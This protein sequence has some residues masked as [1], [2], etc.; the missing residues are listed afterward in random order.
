MN[1]KH[2]I[3]FKITSDYN[4]IREK[5]VFKK[6]LTV[7]MAYAHKL[8][9]SK[10]LR[11]EK[12]KA[13]LAYDMAMETITKYLQE[14]KKFDPNRNPD[15][16]WYLKYNIL[17]QLIYNYKISKG[18]QNELL[19][20]P[21]DGTGS[22]VR[23]SFIQNNEIHDSLDLGIT[24]ELILKEISD[25]PILLELFELRYLK[26]FEPKEIHQELNITKGEYNNRIR[27]LDTVRKRVIKL[28]L[29][30]L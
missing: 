9:G 10:T 14:P 30:E 21:D 27:R 23:N 1:D 4:S 6:L 16:V 15:L 26:E 29:T 20:E 24:L 19:F 11:L 2:S 12:N 3:A 18:Q 28:Q 25:D 5:D 22:I 17:R 7:L 8:I 13:D